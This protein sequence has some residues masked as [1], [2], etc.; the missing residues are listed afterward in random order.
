VGDVVVDADGEMVLRRRL[1]QLVE[2]AL[3]HRRREFL[4]RQAVAAADH[5]LRD[6]AA[7]SQRGD[8][9]EV[10]R[11]AGAPGLLGAVEH[12][13][14]LHDRLGQRFDESA[15]SKRPVQPHFQQAD[16]LAA[17]GSGSRRSSCATSRPSPS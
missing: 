9:V 8:H 14:G 2:D 12:G 10:Q 13:D 4:R 17:R 11:L 3:D 5:L 6:L 15:Q 7:V 16:F 1:G